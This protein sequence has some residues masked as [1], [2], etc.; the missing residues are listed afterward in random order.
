MAGRYPIREETW[1]SLKT[2]DSIEVAYDFDNPNYNFPV[3][4]GTL[5][6]AGMPV[7]LSLFGL[8]SIFVGGFLFTGK[9]PFKRKPLP[10][11]ASPEDGRILRLLEKIKSDSLPIL[12]GNYR[13][14]MVF[15]NGHF[16]EI[17]ILC[18]PQSTHCV[19]CSQTSFQRTPSS[20]LF[21]QSPA[22]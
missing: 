15:S 3:G 13:S 19:I 7:A 20:K 8:I 18:R 1:Y 4:E 9:R 2:G 6:S 11:T 14:H 12:F 17:A 5:A 10:T 16:F 22:E 21:R